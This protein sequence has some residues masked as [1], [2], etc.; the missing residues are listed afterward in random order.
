VKRSE[1][2]WGNCSLHNSFKRKEDVLKGDIEE[3][4]SQIRKYVSQRNEAIRKLNELYDSIDI[5]EQM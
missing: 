3:A 2:L 1:T 4:K 5:K